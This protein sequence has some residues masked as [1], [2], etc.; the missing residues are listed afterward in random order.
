MSCV[1]V[2][3]PTLFK[4]KSKFDRKVGRILSRLRDV[5]VIY[6]QD[7]HGFVRDLISGAIAV[8]NWQNENVTHAIVFD[9]GEEFASELKALRERGTTTRLI[10]TP[11]TRVVN[12]KTDPVYNTRID[13]DGYAYIGRGSYWGN[14]YS[15]HE[16]GATREAVIEKFRYDFENDL[17][18]NKKKKEVFGLTGKRLGCFCKPLACHGD[19]LADYLNRHDDGA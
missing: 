2:L 7:P 4:A 3:Y 13:S 10:H 16:Q 6:E 14:P 5:P 9:D 19:V 11:L 12:V 17:F 1:L 8:Q 18:P 15:M